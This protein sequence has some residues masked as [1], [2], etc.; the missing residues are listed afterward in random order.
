MARTP[1]DPT[2]AQVWI[3]KGLDELDFEFYFPQGAKGDPGG[4]VDGAV[5]ANTSL[6]N[7][8]SAGIYRTLDG[9]FATAINSYPVVGKTGTLLVLAGANASWLMQEYRLIDQMAGSER[10]IYRRVKQG[11]W[12][13]WRAVVTQ[14]VDQTAGRVI[15]QWD[16]VNN[17]EQIIYGDTG[18]RNI[19]QDQA[20]LDALYGTG[21][22]MNSSNV[23]RLRRIGNMVELMWVLDKAAA[24]GI[25]LAGA[26]PVGFR[27]AM[28]WAIMGS[29]SSLG[30]VRAYHPGGA[31]QMIYQANAIQSANSMMAIYSTIDAWP[32]TLPGVAIGAVPNI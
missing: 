23:V 25:T 1:T 26:F 20:W 10:V 31:S 29:N 5:T 32:T 14:R 8:T 18:L 4:I 3:T 28:S 17:R 6:D 9:T 30:Q 13:P 27:P 7:Y 11:T 24:G 12:S 2:K 16:D 22:T 19:Y 21:A 15:Y